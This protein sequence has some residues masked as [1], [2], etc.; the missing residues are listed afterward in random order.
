MDLQFWKDWGEIIAAVIF[1]V[2]AL[3]VAVWI[4]KKQTKTKA[5]SASMQVLPVFSN[6]S[7][8]GNKD[9]ELVYKGRKI[10]DPYFGIIKFKN[11]GQLPILKTDFESGIMMNFASRKEKL[12]P[13]DMMISERNPTNLEVDNDG[14]LLGYGGLNCGLLNPGDEF[15]VNAVFDKKPASIKV[16]ARIVG[17]KEISIDEEGKQGTSLFETLVIS[18]TVPVFYLGFLLATGGL[19][20]YSNGKILLAFAVGSLVFDALRRAY[21]N[22]K[23]KN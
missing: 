3:W 8:G 16:E 15:I 11:S 10:S 20:Y 22:T 21:D 1:G 7:M 12:Y 9:I 17:I 19:Q 23:H 5:I 4:Y 18:L 2:A 14:S 13:I 6:P